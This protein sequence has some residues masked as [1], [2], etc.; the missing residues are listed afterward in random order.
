MRS[1]TLFTTLAL[2]AGVAIAQ[3]T[4][5]PAPAAGATPF[6]IQPGTRIPLSMINSVNTKNSAAGD[7]IYL[8]TVFPILANGKIVIPPGSYVEGTVT[9][10]KRPGRVKGRGSLFVRF[11]SLTLP[12]GV[13]RDFR[14]RVGSIDGRGDEKLERKEGKII[15]ESGKANDAKT[16]AITGASGGLI[17]A[18]LGS[19]AGSMGQGAAIGAGAGVAAGVMMSL[20]SRGPEATLP[21]GSTIEMV[22][23]RPI[24]FVNEEID[25]HGASNP[26]NFTD[27]AGPA[28]KS[29]SGTTVPLRR[30]PI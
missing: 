5:A 25:F 18:G 8:Q 4:P 27:G 6:V 23:D 7:R 2:A 14:A 12:N 15:S 16:I 26:T 24:S 1:A 19:E 11:D 13:T 29:N 3:D 20:L 9:E 22:L 17:G 28:P 10:V 30:L 21:K